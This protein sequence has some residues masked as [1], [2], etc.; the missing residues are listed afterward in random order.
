M[1]QQQCFVSPYECWLPSRKFESIKSFNAL[2][3]HSHDM[4]PMRMLKTLRATI[5]SSAYS[6]CMV[7]TT[8]YVISFEFCD[9]FFG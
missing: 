5:R 6:S 7:E 3:N 4:A 9:N 1:H 8:K 2:N